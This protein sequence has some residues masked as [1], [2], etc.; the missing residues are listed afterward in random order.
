LACSLNLVGDGT[1]LGNTQP[2]DDYFSLVFENQTEESPKSDLEVYLEENVL[3][4]GKGEAFDVLEWWKVNCVKFSVL[5]R[6][7]RDILCILISTIASES[8][9]SARCHILDDYR[10]SLT[11]DMVELL[12]CGGD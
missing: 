11:K 12:V 6:L 10:Y 9:F 5:S 7:V 3:V 2:E 4:V 1:T 8:A